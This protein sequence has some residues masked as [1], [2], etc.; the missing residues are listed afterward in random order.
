MTIREVWLSWIE[1]PGDP[2]AA[3]LRAIEK[4]LKIG[5]QLALRQAMANPSLSPRAAR[6]MGVLEFEGDPLAADY[7]QQLGEVK[8]WLR[9]NAAPV[10]RY[11]EPH[12]AA[13]EIVPGVRVYPLGPPLIQKYFRQMNDSKSDPETYGAS[14]AFS[15]VPAF[16]SPEETPTMSAEKANV[17]T[18]E[19][20][21]R[22]WHSRRESCA[23]WASPTT[24]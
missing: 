12:G 14:F 5:L 10:V 22:R 7:S 24:R 21:E 9:D 3:W 18:R 2:R 13:I 6:L 8:R 17:T 15:A 19:A 1:K 11:L 4:K 16:L 23:R 20:V